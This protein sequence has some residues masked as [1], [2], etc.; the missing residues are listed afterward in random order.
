MI[1]KTISVYSFISVKTN[2][3]TGQF[4]EKQ[5]LLIVYI[6]VNS[7]KVVRK[8]KNKRNRLV[9]IVMFVLALILGWWLFANNSAGKVNAQTSA[10]KINSKKTVTITIRC[11]GDS[12]TGGVGMPDNHQAILGGSSYPS[13]LY[14]LLV[15]NGVNAIVENV[16]YGGEK[17][18]AIVARLGAAELKTNEDLIFDSEGCA[19]PIDDKITAA[20][21]TKT[22]YPITF[23]STD[24]DVNPVIIDGMC[25]EA[26]K[27]KVG[28]QKKVFLYKDK[29]NATTIIKAGSKVKISGTS[30]NSVNIIFAGI[31]DGASYT[32]DDYV[33]M[34]KAG[35]K[36]NGGQYII[37]GPHRSFFNK[38]S[39]VSGADK[40]ERYAN[41]KSR[42][43][44]EFGDHFL[45]LYTDWYENALPIARANGIYTDLSDADINRIQ[46]KLNNRIIP[47]EFTYNGS[48]NNVHLNKAGYTVI[49]QLVYN[50]MVS[51]GYIK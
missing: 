39:F 27:K 4:E 32:I 14:T 6:V 25:Y 36:V 20:Y 49:A 35:A 22:A 40:D 38:S 19:G 24:T 30:K 11:A 37:V 18:S 28:D 7:L 10:E 31:N 3:N 15:D 8:M 48:E 42:M 12:V 2:S 45:D 21:G 34:L 17:T 9:N 33:T 16:G 26:K 50:K 41:Y 23:K 43:Q 51:L 47:S 13:V 44:A 5:L 29:S 1:V 46:D